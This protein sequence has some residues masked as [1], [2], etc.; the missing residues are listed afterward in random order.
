MALM[1]SM[2]LAA[3]QNVWLRE[4]AVH[5]PF[6][7]RSVSRFMPG[8]SLE[9][10]LGAAQSLLQKKIGSVFTHLGENVTERD[11]AWKVTE[12][13]LEV[14]NRIHQLNLPTEVSVKL[15]QLGLDLSAELCFDNLE[16]IIQHE[17]GNSIVWV[18]IEASN[19]VDVT[20]QIYRRALAK[21]PNVGLCLQSYLYRT[22]KDL[23]ELLP[24]RPSIRLV[25]GA[26]KEPA[27]VAYPRK[28]DVD[29]NYFVLAQE[30]LG[31]K[32]AGQCV[33][34]AFGTHDVPLIR[35]LSEYVSQ[36][37]FAKGEFEVQML[38]GIQRGEQERLAAEGHRS[39]VLVAYG[40]YWYP[41][42]VRRLAE[43]PAN[44]WFMLRNVFAS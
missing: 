18:D 25:K 2:L 4:H 8:E 15:T 19:Y 36:Q 27:S 26:Y 43:R 32:A 38:Y 24:L 11:E 21:Y 44:L 42:F 34:A 31:A 33:R 20:L 14:L 9:A 41:W 12:H 16:Q 6:V 39:I 22:K 37:G 10:A 13:Y 28:H 7:R 35:R 30:M 5:Y 1:R 3:S 23:A 17:T 29:E 40:S